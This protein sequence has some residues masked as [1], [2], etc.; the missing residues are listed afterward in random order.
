MS[1]KSSSAMGGGMTPGYGANNSLVSSAIA[2][3][4]P[5]NNFAQTWGTAQSRLRA[6]SLPQSS[7]AA[8]YVGAASNPSTLGLSQLPQMFPGIN[9]NYFQS[10]MKNMGQ[11]TPTAADLGYW[12]RLSMNQTHSI[13]TGVNTSLGGGDASVGQDILGGMSPA[14]AIANVQG[15]PTPAT[16]PV[17]LMLRAGKAQAQTSM[18]PNAPYASAFQNLW[19]GQPQTIA[20]GRYF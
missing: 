3:S 14:K 2:N 4:T 20:Q 1:Q 11:S 19:T 13:P 9:S 6:A 15:A 7:T 10:Y 18:T 5:W 12:T 17:P 8:S 16:T